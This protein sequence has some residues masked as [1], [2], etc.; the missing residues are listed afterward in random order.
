MRSDSWGGPTENKT[1]TTWMCYIVTDTMSPNLQQ[2]REDTQ[3]KEYLRAGDIILQY[4]KLQE[5]NSRVV[6]HIANKDPR[7]TNRNDLEERLQKHMDR[8][9]DKFIPIHVLNMAT[10]GKNFN[11]RM[12]TAVVGGKDVRKMENIFKE[13][14]FNKLELIPFSWKFQDNAGYTRRLKE[15]EGVLKLCKAIKL[16][17]KNIHDDFEDFKGLMEADPAY[18]F[19]VDVF[20]ATHAERT[21]VAYVQYIN[22]HRAAVMGMIQDSIR[23]IKDKQMEAEEETILPFPNGPKIVNTNGAVAPTIQTTTTNKTSTPIPRSKY[24]GLLDQNYEAVS[25][26]HQVP[27]AI[28]VN[29]KSF[30]E[31]ATG[32][33]TFHQDS[34]S[35]TDTFKSGNTS[36]KKSN[37]EAELEEENQQLNKQLCGNS[38][39]RLNLAN[40]DYWI[41]NCEL[42]IFYMNYIKVPS[43]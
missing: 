13:H 26:P 36:G 33:V 29:T 34:D 32:K 39:V 3:V 20:P 35:D 6:F 4:T 37:R 24:G 12:C 18:Q 7:Y 27:W 15:H 25:T 41:N 22:D 2:L 40:K 30:R 14:P 10:N 38:S 42:S 1:K 23:K 28:S 5:S 31:V 43:H 11:T 8:Y 16:E 9:S 17:E 21:G 19:V